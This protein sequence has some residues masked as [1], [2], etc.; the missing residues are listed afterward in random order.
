LTTIE[1]RSALLPYFEDLA[2]KHGEQLID[3]LLYFPNTLSRQEY[4]RDDARSTSKKDG[5]LMK[6]ARL[7]SGGHLHLSLAYLLTFWLRP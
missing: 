2:I 5:I 7:E 3:V 1:I 4:T 6:L